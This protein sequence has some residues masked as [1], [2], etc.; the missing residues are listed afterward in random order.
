MLPIKL[1]VVEV[2]PRTL[3]TCSFCSLFGGFR[4]L[5]VRG[6]WGWSLSSSLQGSRREGRLKGLG[7]GL[8]LSRAERSKGRMLNDQIPI[9]VYPL[10]SI[11]TTGS[12]GVRVVRCLPFSMP[13]KWVPAIARGGQSEQ[14]SLQ[15]RT[16]C[17]G[18]G[19]VEVGR[20]I[21]RRIQWHLVL[22]TYQG[23]WH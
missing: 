15:R 19:F 12:E 16:G 2:G 9:F 1:I 22:V 21:L 3:G 17:I 5:E 13:R 23:S 18:L 7:K 14:D 20:C 6:R 11:I 4:D 10:F 8:Q